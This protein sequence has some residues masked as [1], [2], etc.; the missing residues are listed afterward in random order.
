MTAGYAE[1]DE[2]STALLAK[3]TD[4]GKLCAH[5]G[6]EFT[7]PHGSPTACT[8]CF[9]RLSAD[10]RGDTP[11]AVHPEVNKEAHAQQARA[12]RARKEGR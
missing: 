2:V 10:E 11:L 8:Y 5:C 3:W 6:A 4:A 9:R 12:R 7:K 1:G